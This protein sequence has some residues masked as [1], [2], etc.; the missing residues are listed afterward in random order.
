MVAHPSQRPASHVSLPTM[1]RMHYWYGQG[2]LVNGLCLSRRARK[3]TPVRR[4]NC[5][6]WA[7]TSSWH[8]REMAMGTVEARTALRTS[9]LIV[10]HVDWANRWLNT[11]VG[12]YQTS[13]PSRYFKRH[14]LA[15]E[16]F[17]LLTMEIFF[18]REFVVKLDF[19]DNEKWKFVCR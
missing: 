2:S 10:F 8:C 5:T 19:V 1:F 11:F 12:P 14:M 15:P 3:E 17:R 7:I 6:L 9:T 13:R 16:F 4:A 18:R